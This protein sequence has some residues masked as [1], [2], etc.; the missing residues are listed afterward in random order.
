MATFLAL[1]PCLPKFHLPPRPQQ[2]GVPQ[3]LPDSSRPHPESCPPSP[4]QHRAKG[5]ASPAFPPLKGLRPPHQLW[6]R[7]HQPGWPAAFQLS[8]AR[9]SSSSTQSP[10]PREP[11][12][13][14]PPQH[15]GQEPRRLQML[16][17]LF[18]SP[19]SCAPHLF[20]PAVTQGEEDTGSSPCL[21]VNRASRDNSWGY[22][23]GLTKSSW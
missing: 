2:R 22:G 15:P 7:H 14:H 16:P 9:H 18:P 12:H 4:S 17:L 23:E 10:T 8:V 6:A 20:T 5:A 11:K 21:R 3:I 1:P 13:R 19:C